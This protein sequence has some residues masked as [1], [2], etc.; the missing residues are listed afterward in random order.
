MFSFTDKLI[1]KIFFYTILIAS[2]LGCTPKTS[3]NTEVSGNQK[4]CSLV[5]YSPQLAI[6]FNLINA[7]EKNYK[8]FINNEEASPNCASSILDCPVFH[9]TI[10]ENVLSFRFGVK[11][12]VD[13]LDVK[14]VATDKDQTVTTLERNNEVI[15]W[16]DIYIED[17]CQNS[18][19]GQ[20][21]INE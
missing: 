16:K 10:H 9:K 17:N 19:D 20:L 11:S 7:A 2:I 3:K 1:M 15:S 21:D 4:I 12:K 13:K 6:N 18:F 5:G 14:L 8:L